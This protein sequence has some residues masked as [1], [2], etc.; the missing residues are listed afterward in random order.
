MLLEGGS[1]QDYEEIISK[2]NINDD[3]KQLHKTTSI[4]LNNLHPS[5]KRSELEDVV[6]KFPGFLRLALSE[7]DPNN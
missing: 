3:S 1:E 4:F 2:E 5:I 7:P 6:K